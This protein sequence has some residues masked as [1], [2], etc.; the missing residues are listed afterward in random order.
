MTHVLYKLAH[1]CCPISTHP[2]ALKSYTFKCRLST[3]CLNVSEDFH[4]T[5]MVD[6]SLA[7]KNQWSFECIVNSWY[8]IPAWDLITLTDFAGCLYRDPQWMSAAVDTSRIQEIN[9]EIKVKYTFSKLCII[10]E[11]HVTT[12]WGGGV[13]FSVAFVTL[14]FT[15]MHPF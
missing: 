14:V 4:S 3:S 7:V 15:V 8:M 11:V 6:N 12:Y 2:S 10:G 1:C 13:F 5:G 9:N